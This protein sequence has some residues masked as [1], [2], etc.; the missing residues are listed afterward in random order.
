MNRSSAPGVKSIAGDAGEND[1]GEPGGVSRLI[2]L[3]SLSNLGN[4]HS[5]R[6]KS[7]F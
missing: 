3:L 2:Q 4:G 1:N 7:G 5:E 6:N